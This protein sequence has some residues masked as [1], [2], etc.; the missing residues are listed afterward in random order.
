MIQ[1]HTLNLNK[2]QKAVFNT[3]KIKYSLSYTSLISPFSI[4]QTRLLNCRSFKNRNKLFVKQSYLLVTWI[5]Y[6]TSSLDLKLGNDNKSTSGDNEKQ[7]PENLSNIRSVRPGFFVQPVRVFK[8]TLTKAPMAHKTFSQEQ[9][10]VKFYKLSISFNFPNQTHLNTL[11]LNK[12]LY[13]LIKFKTFLFGT[14]S[15]LFFL[16]RTQLSLRVSD[17]NFFKTL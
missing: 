13:T 17:T 14:N 12:S 3:K 7:S 16:K 1:I 4:K 2:T 9:Y 15:N 11:D 6:L 8:T 10:L 5:A